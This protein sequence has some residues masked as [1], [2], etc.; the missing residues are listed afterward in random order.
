MALRANPG[1]SNVRIAKARLLIAAQL[2]QRALAV[3]DAGL[4]CAASDLVLLIAAAQIAL[5]V[6]AARALEYAQRALQ[7][8]PEDHV[9]RVAFGNAALA[10]GSARQA[11]ETAEW[12]GRRDPADGQALTIRVDAWRLLGDERYRALA[13]YA[14]F[15]RAGLIDTPAGWPDL[16]AYLADLVRAV[17]RLHTLHVHPI[18][19]SLRGGGQISLRPEHSPDPAIRAFP[20]AIDGPI[21]RYMTALGSGDDALRRRNTG[22]YRLH[23]AWSVRLHPDGFHVNHY[24][25]QGWLSSACYLRL[26]P[27]V[28]SRN[29]EGWLRFGEPAFA[30]LP[31]WQRSIS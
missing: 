25:P 22:S 2:P 23:S 5:D 29:G 13:D 18:G 8:A 4:A 9:A 21:R 14:K 17:D 26:P 24:H 19:Q 3:I 31:G 6:D 30:T 28:G 1:L 10:V 11:L 27:V 12:L 7:V 20:Q 15:V 16:P